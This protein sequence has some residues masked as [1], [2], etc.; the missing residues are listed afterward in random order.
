[1]KK[2]SRFSKIYSIILL[3]G[4]SLVLSG[5]LMSIEPAASIYDVSASGPSDY[6][7]VKFEV[8]LHLTEI[9]DSDFHIYSGRGV[10]L[11][12][13]FSG[14]YLQVDLQDLYDTYL[15]INSPL[16]NFGT[17]TVVI[18]QRLKPKNGEVV[19]HSW[20]VKFW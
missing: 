14:P 6:P 18:E 4:T 1:M 5:C 12:S 11:G 16:L 19:S 10:Q 13:K 3:F 7:D 20:L 17:G 8:T 15:E 2:R 9:D